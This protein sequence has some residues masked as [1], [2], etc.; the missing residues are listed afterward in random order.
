MA[1]EALL[2]QT[3]VELAD[4]LVDSFD[5]IEFLHLLTDR[6]VALLGVNEAGVV[7]ADPAGNPCCVMEQRA[8][9]ADTGPI[10]AL[11]LDSA[12]PERD[13]EF[14]AWLTGWIE[15]PGDADR[16]LRHPSLK[17]PYLELH[18][19]RAAKGPAKNRLHLDIRLEAGDDPDELAAGIAGRGGRELQMG[20]GD[21]PWRHF[22]DPS[23][24]E[25]CLLPART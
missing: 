1:R 6:C 4:T 2:G 7:L 18:R 25:L 8:T 20:W 5:L 13:A 12:D 17:G 9:Y 16:A 22:A 14:W 10:A 11:P 23:G 3:F 19:E 21:L 15:V 24:N